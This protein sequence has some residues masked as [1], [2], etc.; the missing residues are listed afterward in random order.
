M[1]YDDVKPGFY[2][3]VDVEGARVAPLWVTGR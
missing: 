1:E 3:V 2:L